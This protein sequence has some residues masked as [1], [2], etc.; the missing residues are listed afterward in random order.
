MRS[1]QS[2]ESFRKTPTRTLRAT[3][4]KRWCGTMSL[5][6]W[7]SSHDIPAH[8]VL[9]I[10]RHVAHLLLLYGEVGVHDEGVEDRTGEIQSHD[11]HPTSPDARGEE[12]IRRVGCTIPSQSTE[13]R[14][15]MV[16]LYMRLQREDIDI[17][18]AHLQDH[19]CLQEA[20]VIINAMRAT[21]AFIATI[22]LT[23]K[24]PVSEYM[25]EY[26]SGAQSRASQKPT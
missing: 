3:L 23:W 25:W 16:R 10:V 1:G 22:P 7:R 9:Y 15:V 4:R 2:T 14:C 21:Y 12:R 26:S 19:S 20:R 5:Q 18:E 17:I 8:H 6:R 13:R 11:D 24:G